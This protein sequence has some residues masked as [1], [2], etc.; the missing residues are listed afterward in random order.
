MQQ[1]GC[2]MML[3]SSISL[4]METRGMP[5]TFGVFGKY[6][7]CRSSTEAGGN[8]ERSVTSV[9]VCKGL[10]AKSSREICLSKEW[11]ARECEE[12]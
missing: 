10:S 7:L 1:I 8:A 4:M 6:S 3:M 5:R 11:E 12:L 2:K 9:E